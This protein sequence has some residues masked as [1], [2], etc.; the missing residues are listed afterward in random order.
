M[1]EMKEPE[2]LEQLRRFLGMVNYVS[3][4]LPDAA[5]TT[6]PLTNLLKGD[7]PWTWSKNQQEAFEAINDMFC[8]TP[9]LAY[10]D[11]KIPLVLKNDASEY[12]LGS[13][14]SRTAN[15]LLSRAA[16]SRKQKDATPKSK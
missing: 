1:K 9:V 7:T 16:H 13:R 4:F 11:H 12:R 3:K 14:Y 10:Y 6:Q 2:N 8:S 15:L 5:S